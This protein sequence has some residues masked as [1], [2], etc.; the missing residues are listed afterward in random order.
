MCV[1]EL[2]SKHDRD[3]ESNELASSLSVHLLLLRP[4]IIAAE[5]VHGGALADG[6]ADE[7]VNES[8][9][10]PSYSLSWT[11]RDTKVW[12]HSREAVT[13]VAAK[14]TAKVRTKKV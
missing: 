1:R 3:R 11:L 13:M 8:K 10:L 2:G 14:K 4:V 9:L 6:R 5:H 12:R 7:Q